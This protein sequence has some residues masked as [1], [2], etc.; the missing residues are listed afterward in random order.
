MVRTE[1]EW[2]PRLWVS[3]P[4]SIPSVSIAAGQNH[5][6]DLSVKPRPG[7]ALSATVRPI[8]PNEPHETLDV[9]FIF[10]AG[11]IE[12]TLRKTVGVRFRPSFWS[13]G[14]AL[15]VGSFLGSLVRVVIRVFRPPG[16]T[17]AK[18]LKV[19]IWIWLRDFLSAIVLGI[20]LEAL[21]LILFMANSRLRLF[22]LELD[23]WQPLQVFFIGVM[24]A[25]GITKAATLLEDLLKMPGYLTDRP[26]TPPDPAPETVIEGG[27]PGGPA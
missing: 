14:L 11:G 6:I 16:D 3:H 4:P 27:A 2:D 26:K 25:L 15:L 20:V 23:P 7:A 17:P 21:G 13:L 1:I 18:S 10:T 12:R 22:G 24:A 8:L 5:P 19:K 9:R